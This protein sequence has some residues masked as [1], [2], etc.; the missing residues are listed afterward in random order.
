MAS[1][2]DYHDHLKS[3]T[4]HALIVTCSGIS[5]LRKKIQRVRTPCERQL[6]A[7]QASYARGIT[8]NQ[9]STENKRLRP[10]HRILAR[11]GVQGEHQS[12]TFDHTE[13]QY[14]FTVTGPLLF[15]KSVKNK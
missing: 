7:G 6:C 11:K 13:I 12:L 3:K 9:T 14:V 1:E 15:D 4:D 5:W 2:S 8:G 10:G